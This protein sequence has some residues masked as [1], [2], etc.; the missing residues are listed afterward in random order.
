ML[1]LIHDVRFPY[2]DRHPHLF[3][4]FLQRLHV[5]ITP[6]IVNDG[7]GA[8]GIRQHRMDVL[9]ISRLDQERMEAVLRAL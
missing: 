4:I 1:R 9:D 2:S 7:H 6:R 8:V 3:H 5:L